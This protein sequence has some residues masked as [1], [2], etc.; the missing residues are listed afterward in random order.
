MAKFEKYEAGDS[1]GKNNVNL[2]N[3]SPLLYSQELSIVGSRDFAEPLFFQRK[4]YT[5]WKTISKVDWAKPLLLS[6]REHC[7][8]GAGVPIKP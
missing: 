3:Q 6:M 5:P 2:Q 8:L 7:L 4:G 1:T